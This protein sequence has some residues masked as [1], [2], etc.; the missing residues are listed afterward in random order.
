MTPAAPNALFITFEGIE[1]AGKS[2]QIKRLAASL[3]DMGLRVLTTREPGGTPLAE[4]I[5]NL[6]LTPNDERIAPQTELL[7]MAA[8]RSQHVHEILYPASTQHDVILCDRYIDSSMAYQGAGRDLGTEE[9][10]NI[11]HFATSGLMPHIT[12]ILDIPVELSLKRMRIRDQSRHHKEDRFEKEHRPFF[13]TLRD[14]FLS[15]ADQD[16]ERCIVLDGTQSL[17]T[18]ERLQKDVILERLRAR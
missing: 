5:R 9:V 6:L 18:L 7:L 4:D 17:D 3:E 12:F 10:A 1:G 13:E 11:N 14:A 8:A 2:T 16:P 15:I